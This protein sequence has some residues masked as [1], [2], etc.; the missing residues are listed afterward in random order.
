MKLKYTR[1][2]GLPSRVSVAG[3]ERADVLVKEGG[4]LQQPQ[5]Q[6]TLDSVLS[7]I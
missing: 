1:S 6:M 3:N 7:C 2:Q 5:K 4:E